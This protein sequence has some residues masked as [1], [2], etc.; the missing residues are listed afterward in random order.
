MRQVGY[1]QGSYLTVPQYKRS[2]AQVRMEEEQSTI[3]SMIRLKRKV[4][5][6]YVEGTSKLNA[7]T[8]WSKYYV[9]WTVHH[10]DS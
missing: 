3:F 1:L 6:V 2:L 4:W 7:L 8:N 9:Y 10:C 5:A